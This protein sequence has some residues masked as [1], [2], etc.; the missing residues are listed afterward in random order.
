M[1]SEMICCSPD[2]LLPIALMGYCLTPQECPPL[3]FSTRCGLAS[4]STTSQRRR[5]GTTIDAR[6]RVT[7]TD[8]VSLITL[9]I[10]LDTQIHIYVHFCVKHRASVGPHRAHYIKTTVQARADVTWYHCVLIPW[11]FRVAF[12]SLVSVVQD[13]SFPHFV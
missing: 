11:S 5:T 2:P 13:Y 7:T 12:G 6:L 3:T 1:S 10:F 8:S 9:L 4:C